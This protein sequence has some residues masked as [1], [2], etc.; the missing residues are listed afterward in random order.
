MDSAGKG[1]TNKERDKNLMDGWRVGERKG[2][3][4]GQRE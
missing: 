3:T 4:D 2:G 1:D